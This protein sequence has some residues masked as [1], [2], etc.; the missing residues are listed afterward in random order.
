MKLTAA[1]TTQSLI[2]VA[3]LLALTSHA[4]WAQEATGARRGWT[5]EPSVSL[6]QTFTDNQRLQTVKES[7]S[8]TEGSAGLRIGNTGGIVRGFADYSLTASAY[9][10]N[11]SA[12]E[13]RHFLSAALALS[14]CAATTRNKRSRPSAA[15]R[16]ARD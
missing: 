16:P 4:A 7:D 1:I 10:R 13:L 14:T 11:D 8:I 3:A 9:A 2:T 5:I 15:R 6:R 12:N